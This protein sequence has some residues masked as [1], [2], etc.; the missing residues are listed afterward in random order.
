MSAPVIADPDA[1][2]TDI[3]FSEDGVYVVTL[4]ATLGAVVLTATKEVTVETP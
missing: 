2:Q 1:Q 3:T 4:T